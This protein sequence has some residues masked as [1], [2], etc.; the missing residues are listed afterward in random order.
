[1]RK[2]NQTDTTRVNEDI[3]APEVRLI[4]DDGKQ[5]GIVSRQRAL[6]EAERRNLDLVEVASGANPPVCRIIDYSK[7][8]YEQTRREKDSRKQS[9]K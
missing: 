6:E 7:Y 9:Q 1:M 5:L 2:Y 3:K 8:R 4:A